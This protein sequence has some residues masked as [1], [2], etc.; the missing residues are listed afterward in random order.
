MFRLFS[1]SSPIF[2][3]STAIS[4]V[5]FPLGLFSFDPHLGHLL[6]L[7]SYSFSVSQTIEITQ[8]NGAWL[9]PPAG[10]FVNIF[11]GNFLIA[12]FPD[13]IGHSLLIFHVFA[14]GIA[15]FSYFLMLSL[16]FHQLYCCPPPLREMAP[17]LAVPL[18]PPGVSVIALLSLEKALDHFPQLDSLQNNL[19]PFIHVYVPFVIGYGC[20]WAILAALIMV[21]YVKE[22]N[23]PFTLGFW[24]FVFPIAAFG[25]AIFLTAQNPLFSFLNGVAIFLWGISLLLWGFTTYQNLLR[26]LPRN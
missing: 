6:A 9:L 1:T 15:F 7:I 23:I 12:H 10:L 25:I 2:L 20:F 18:A 21:R 13:F 22:K 14:L 24:A 19:S 16:L 11:A 3:L 8:A 26:F 5:M 4:N 17:A